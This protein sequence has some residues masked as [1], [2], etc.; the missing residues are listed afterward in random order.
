LF[1]AGAQGIGVAILGMFFYGEAVQRLGAPRAAIFGALA[2][3]L[4]VLIGIPV[5]GEIPRPSTLAGVILVMSGVYLV[6]TQG[7]GSALV[8]RD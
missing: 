3:A 8:R 7:T 6:V 5:L 4:A 2:P 1:Q